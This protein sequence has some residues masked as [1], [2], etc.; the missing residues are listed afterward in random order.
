MSTKRVFMLTRAFSKTV[1]NS[2]L[3]FPI[4]RAWV[5]EIHSDK[6]TSVDWSNPF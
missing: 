3:K 6:A 2:I 5:S 4:L 1:G